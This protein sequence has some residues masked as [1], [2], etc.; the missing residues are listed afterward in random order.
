MRND[1]GNSGLVEWLVKKKNWEIPDWLCV[2]GEMKTN[3]ENEA[4]F[5]S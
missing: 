3:P 2:N 1:R 4:I 5:T